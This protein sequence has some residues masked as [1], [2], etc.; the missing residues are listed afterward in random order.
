LLIQKKLATRA[1]AS[2]KRLR[3]WITLPTVSRGS[4]YMNFSS[5][6]GI[7]LNFDWPE[8][9]FAI[10]HAALVNSSSVKADWRKP[11]R[12][13]PSAKDEIIAGI[14][15]YALGHH[16]ACVFYMCRVGELGLRII[17]RE[18]GIK[19]LANRKTPIEYGTWGQVI[20]AIQPTIE[21]IKNHK[22][23]GPQ[24]E[25]ALKFYETV[26][27]D[28][29]AIQNLRDPTMHFRDSYDKGQAESAIFRVKQLM[30]TLA[31]KLDENSTRA[32]PWVSWK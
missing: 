20:N 21:K 2:K 18:R 22:A 5:V 24:K 6:Y 1:P 13:F 12:A 4:N 26:I 19:K 9:F 29:R 25:A 16:P 27:S 32:I 15:C 30:T 7:W 31:E 23:K 8:S 17:G 28:L 10:I 11:I 14:D 3:R